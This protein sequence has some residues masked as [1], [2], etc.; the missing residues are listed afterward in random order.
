MIELSPGEK[1]EF[2]T[3]EDDPEQKY[4]IS[5]FGRV[6]SLKSKKFIKLNINSCGYARA[7]VTYF[8]KINDIYKRI[9]QKQIFVHIE[10]VKVFG[11]C[12]GNSFN[13]LKKYID[14][15]NI[16][17]INKNR[18]DC[19]QSNLQIVSFAENQRRKYLKGEEREEFLKNHLKK[20]QDSMNEL[21]I[22]DIF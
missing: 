5:S 21:A 3:R 7:E 10:V 15:V 20:I 9:Y 8:K 13:K 1:L 4:M 12:Y 6:Y 17:H 18:L 19:R 11:D 2:F 14:I 16:D 22:E